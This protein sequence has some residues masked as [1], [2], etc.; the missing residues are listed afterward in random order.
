LKSGNA[1]PARFELWQRFG[2]WSSFDNYL[3]RAKLMTGDIPCSQ[4]AIDVPN[5]VDADPEVNE[6]SRLS[7]PVGG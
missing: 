3:P 1:V 2:T 5:Y 7:G 4:H 6:L